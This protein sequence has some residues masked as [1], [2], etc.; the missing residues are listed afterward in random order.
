MDNTTEISKSEYGEVSVTFT[1]ARMPSDI[2][3][4]LARSIKELGLPVVG[5]KAQLLVESEPG[6]TWIKRADKS[7]V[8]TYG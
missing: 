5:T 2:N 8:T 1:T 4:F 6:R 7:S 3:R